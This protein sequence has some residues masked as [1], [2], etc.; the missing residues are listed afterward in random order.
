MAPHEFPWQQMVCLWPLILYIPGLLKA[1]HSLVCVC[2][3]VCGWERGAPTYTTVWQ[4]KWMCWSGNLSHLGTYAERALHSNKWPS[5]A[6]SFCVLQNQHYSLG[7]V[8]MMQTR[9]ILANQGNVDTDKQNTWKLAQNCSLVVNMQPISSCVQQSSDALGCDTTTQW[10]EET[11]LIHTSSHE[12]HTSFEVEEL[13]W[14]GGRGGDRSPGG[15]PPIRHINLLDCI[16]VAELECAQ[17]SDTWQPA[18][19]QHLVDSEQHSALC[20]PTHGW[21][22]P[23]CLQSGGRKSTNFTAELHQLA[24]TWH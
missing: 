20:T 15:G 1:D 11:H 4:T 24:K 8:M 19:V 12:L 13:Q 18:H 16:S 23:T 9:W 21:S 10:A 3:C 5:G 2:T 22:H 7:K 17:P 14:L 6:T